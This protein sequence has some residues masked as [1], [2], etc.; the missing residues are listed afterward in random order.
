MSYDV[1]S[2]VG[3]A[4]RVAIARAAGPL[5]STRTSHVSRD[6]GVKSSEVVAASKA[7]C[8]LEERILL[9]EIGAR[10]EGGDDVS[11][12]DESDDDIECCKVEI[13]PT[14]R[15]GETKASIDVIDGSTTTTAATWR[16]RTFIVA[17]NRLLGV[18]RKFIVI[19]IDIKCVV[20][21]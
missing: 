21:S 4:R 19:A 11:P 18:K 1:E 9:M 6:V 5:P 14:R 10:C 8:L 16:A 17:I 7:V 2:D 15:I 12:S 20:S 13:E 3:E